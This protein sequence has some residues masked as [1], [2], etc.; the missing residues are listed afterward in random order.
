M[1]L[2]LEIVWKM[3][4]DYLERSAA[5]TEDGLDTLNKW[6]F[7]YTIAASIALAT[8]AGA[9]IKFFGF[10]GDLPDVIHCVHTLGYVPMHQ[11]LP[12]VSVWR[13]SNPFNAC[14][15]SRMY[16]LCLPAVFR[17]SP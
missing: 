10:P 13:E 3:I 15:W 17:P 5:E 12:M 4:P 16:H 1:E 6:G 9:S 2:S 7:L 14:C 11:T 8:A